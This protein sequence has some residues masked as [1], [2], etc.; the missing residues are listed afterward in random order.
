MRDYCGVGIVIL[1]L[2]AVT[3]LTI[4]FLKVGEPTGRLVELLFPRI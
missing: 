3:G 1:V 4:F 2:F